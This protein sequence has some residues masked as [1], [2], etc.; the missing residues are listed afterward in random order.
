MAA[1]STAMQPERMPGRSASGFAGCGRPHTIR[2]E[3]ADRRVLP[4]H[5]VMHGVHP[6]G[7]ADKRQWRE[8]T[9]RDGHIRCCDR[10]SSGSGVAFGQA[11]RSPQNLPASRH[12]GQRT[13]ISILICSCN[14]AAREI[15]QKRKQ[16]RIA[17]F[18]YVEWL[19]MLCSVLALSSHPSFQPL[20][21]DDAQRVSRAKARCLACETRSRAQRSGSQVQPAQGARVGPNS[22]AARS[23]ASPMKRQQS[24]NNDNEKTTRG[25]Q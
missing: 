13:I 9:G 4:A 24:D 25:P 19:A 14:W 21:H 12:I 10:R 16:R 2:I 7:V 15:T 3:V 6:P 18:A 23:R 22:A 1:R 8:K 17:W 11:H 20:I 5:R